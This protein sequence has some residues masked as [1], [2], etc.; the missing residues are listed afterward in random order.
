MWKKFLVFCIFLTAIIILHIF[1]SSYNYQSVSK[2]DEEPAWVRALVFMRDGLL[3]LHLLHNN[4]DR[5]P[6]VG[7]LKQDLSVSDVE[8]FL[9]VQGFTPDPFAWEKTNE[10]VNYRKTDDQG[11]QYHVT[12][13]SDDNSVYGHHEFIPEE[14]P[15]R[16]Y[17]DMEMEPRHA[18][19]LRMLAPIL[20]ASSL[21]GSIVTQ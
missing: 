13:F 12:V 5:G 14:F 2:I 15:L 11:Y 6:Y 9:Q 20:V 1:M 18:E 7:Q 16:H 19:F 10:A 8:Q 3:H 4:E 21:P 17:K